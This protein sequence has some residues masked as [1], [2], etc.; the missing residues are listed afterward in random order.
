MKAGKKMEKARVQLLLDNPFFGHLASYLEL[1]DDESL[2][3]PIGTD[4]K[5]IYFNPKMIENLDESKVKSC[6]AHGILHTALGHQW[7]RES[8]SEETWNSA[9]DIAINW[10]LKES[11]FELPP[12]LR[13]RS[14]FKN[15]SAEEI[16]SEITL[17]EKK[18]QKGSEK[19]SDKKKRQKKRF[20]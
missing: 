8:R 4:H 13:L 18:N 3:N 17:E 19:N 11:G 10:I 15:K 1:K 2:D 16:Y 6:I 14:D 7:R 5:K 9:T 12:K 20:R